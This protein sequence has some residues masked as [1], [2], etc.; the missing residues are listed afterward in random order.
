MEVKKLNQ[1]WKA[2]NWPEFNV[3]VGVNTGEMIFGNIGSSRAMGLT[4]IGRS[5]NQAQRLESKAETG[6]VWISG[7]VAGEIDLKKFP[8]EHLGEIQAKGVNLDAYR[9]RV[10]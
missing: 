10:Y 8:F 5:V 6:E 9:L 1:K 7:K 3:G 2:K 4:V